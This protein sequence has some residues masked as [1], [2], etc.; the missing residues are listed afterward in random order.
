LN[1]WLVEFIQSSFSA[2]R[3]DRVIE[4]QPNLPYRW[5]GS[6]VGK[7]LKPMKKF[8]TRTARSFSINV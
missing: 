8:S 6:D 2:A 7:V 4:I 3:S 5:H 1:S